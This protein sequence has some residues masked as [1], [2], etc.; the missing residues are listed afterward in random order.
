MKKKIC[1]WWFTFT[2]IA[3]LLVVVS[4][5]AAT[6]SNTPLVPRSLQSTDRVPMGYS[7]NTNAYTLSIGQVSQYVQQD[8]SSSMRR[9]MYDPTGIRSSAFAR[10]NHT[11]TQPASTITGLAAV[12]TQG[13]YSSLTSK[14]AIPTT[15]Q[16]NSWNAKQ[17]ALTVGIDY[18]APTGNGSGLSG[19]TASQVSGLPADVSA[20]KYIVQTADSA[21]PGA[22][23]LAALG[24]GLVKNTTG[25]GV[26]SVGAAAT[27]YVAPSAYASANGLTMSTGKMLGRTTASTGAAEEI[28]IG[29]GLSLS[30]GTLA[31]TSGG[32]SVTSTSVVTANGFGGT[33]ATST[34]TP[35]ITLTTGVTGIMKGN[36]T[37]ASA[38]SAGTDYVAP[39][40][41]ASSNGLTLTSGKLLGRTTTSTG[42]A[43]E[44]T[45]GS[46]LL[47]SA[48]S[49]TATGGGGSV[50]TASVVSAN[51]FAGTVANA[52]TTPAITLT[53]NVTGLLKGNGTAV[54]AASAGTDYVAPSAY[55]SANGHTMS[56][57]RLLGRTTASTGAAEEISVGSGLSLSGGSL[58]ATGGS[59]TVTA[60]S[61]TT[62]NGVSGS[63]SG[64]ATPALTLTLGAITPTTVN[65]NTITTGTGTLTLAAGK[66][67]TASNSITIAGTD[68]STLNVGTGGTLGTS[69]Y[70]AG[71]SGAM[72]G[73][74]DTQTLSA[75]TLT[76][77]II[78]GYTETVYTPTVTS[79]AVT[80][81]LAN[82][83][84]QKVV[85]AANTTITLPSAAA[86]TSYTVLVSY[87]GTHTV[88]WAGGGTIKFAGG[89]APVATSTSGH[90]DIY[91]FVCH[92]STNTFGSDGG[93]NY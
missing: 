83:T 57:A 35:A 34:S 70:M 38:A 17:N 49:L 79:G 5:N 33:V 45:V 3:S 27:D 90:Y 52:S 51:G 55:A 78:T 50:T 89:T 2:V 53:T 25:T 16:I 80:I 10:A 47:L 56:T 36:G 23:A 58:T 93:R 81:S 24:T 65:G 7:G 72:V 13:T 74:T 84:L 87:G 12:A 66:T 64:G 48:G 1:Q 19:I 9:S 67:L 8:Y 77:P 26:L 62:A 82:G 59:G 21:L 85:T 40:A 92:D 14:P 39:S 32:G 31:S 43:E 86:G 18:V 22:Q 29:S 73:T 76:G 75:K 41:Y 28:T 20:K 30:G 88:T 37:G 4:L 54:S 60:I 6:I 63:S 46:G 68:S 71:P 61:V 11:G 69:A 91:T 44:I 15:A 42:A